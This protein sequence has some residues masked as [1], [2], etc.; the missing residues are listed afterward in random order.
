MDTNKKIKLLDFKLTKSLW[1]SLFWIYKSK[2]SWTWMDFV[3]HKEYIFWDPIKNI[4]WKTLS[5]TQKLHTKVFEEDR[6]LK[7]LFLID[8][9]LNL[10]F[11]IF[12][13]TKKDILEEVFYSLSFSSYNSWDTIWAYIYWL[14]E[15]KYFDYQKWIWNIFWVIKFL[16]GEV[17]NRKIDNNRTNLMLNYLSNKNTKNN[18]IFILSDDLDFIDEK[19]LKVL[20]IDNQIIFINI[21]DDFENNLLNIPWDISL[22]NWN[23]FSFISLSNDKKIEEYKKIRKFKISNFENSLKKNKISYLML[24]TKKDI[25]KELYLFFSKLK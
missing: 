21:F 18:L 13:K 23:S 11:Q 24:D 14:D 15:F 12:E 22:S 6:D 1:N 8:F 3:E 20:S 19:L 10:D 5:R 16:N 4:D 17:L 7:V 2:F 25:F 9:N